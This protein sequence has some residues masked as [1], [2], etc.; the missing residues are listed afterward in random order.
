M[1]LW[2]GDRDRNYFSEATGVFLDIGGLTSDYI[3]AP[4]QPGPRPSPATRQ[5]S[6]RRNLT[7]FTRLSSA[8]RGLQGW[9]GEGGDSLNVA[10]AVRGQYAALMW[11][12]RGEARRGQWK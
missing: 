12:V 3:I 8:G 11:R 9:V 1:I 10:A 2:L 7:Y 6:F 5:D 4:G